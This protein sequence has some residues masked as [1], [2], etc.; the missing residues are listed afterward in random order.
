M[1]EMFK[2]KCCKQRGQVKF[3]GTMTKRP[4]QKHTEHN[5]TQSIQRRNRR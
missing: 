2:E 4:V 1:E 3:M 5:K